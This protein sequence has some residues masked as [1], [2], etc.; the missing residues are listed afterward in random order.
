M[1]SFASTTALIVLTLLGA[2]LAGSQVAPKH[3]MDD[4]FTKPAPRA[5]ALLDATLQ[6]SPEVL[7]MMMHV[8]PPNRRLNVVIAS[9]IGRIGEIGDKDDLRCI[10]T[11]KSNLEVNTAGNHFEDELALKDQSGRIVGAIGIV[12]NYRSG[13][14]R[15]A[16][17]ATANRIRAALAKQIENKRS[18]FD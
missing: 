6:S 12:F 7:A 4:G 16:L 2:N 9:N 11:G 18:L 3:E 5:Q 17:V 8:R 10:R 14:D 15:S 1:K 13:D